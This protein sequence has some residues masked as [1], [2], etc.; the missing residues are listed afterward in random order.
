MIALLVDPA[1][2]TGDHAV[3][4]DQLNAIPVPQGVA[5]GSTMGKHIALFSAF[6][7]IRRDS[8]V[9][10]THSEGMYGKRT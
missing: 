1:P 8:N 7:R 6:W 3:R 9:G 10:F 4:M 2:Q 5:A